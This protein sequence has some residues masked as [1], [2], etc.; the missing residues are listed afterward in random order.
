MKKSTDKWIRKSI[1]LS[2]HTEEVAQKLADKWY[3]G[4]LSALISSRIE[5][6]ERC[7]HCRLDNTFN[8]Q[9]FE[10]PVS[11]NNIL[12]SM[13]QKNKRKTSNT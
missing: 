13:P 1:I 11:T 2:A 10:A 5:Q 8:I 6:A 3:A 4:N 7:E 12:Q 9:N